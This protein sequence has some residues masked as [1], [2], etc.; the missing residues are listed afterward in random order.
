M[1]ITFSGTPSCGKSLNARRLANDLGWERRSVGDIM[2]ELAAEK[3]LSINQFYA[4]LDEA[5]ERTIDNRQREWGKTLDDFIIEGRTSFIM[6]PESKRYNIFLSL[7]MDIAAERAYAKEGQ[8]DYASV[9]DAKVKLADRL[10]MENERYK[11]LYG[12]DHLNMKHYDAVIDA[13]GS[14]EEVYN[15]IYNTV[16]HEMLRRGYT[17]LR[18]Q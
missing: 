5:A 8:T 10:S 13:S 1:I 7:P 12:V 17:A 4:T 16:Q 6:M 3:G 18:H 11:K 15:Q 2:K 14:P 9:Q